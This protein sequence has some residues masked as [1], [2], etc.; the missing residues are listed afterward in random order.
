MSL[1]RII[2]YGSFDNIYLCGPESLI[3][4]ANK[5]L[6]SIGIDAKKIHFE[7]FTIPG[8]ATSVKSQ[9][10]SDSEI[11]ESPKS[12]I[13]IK[14]DGRS[15]GFELP[16]TGISI[17]DGALQQGADLPYACKGGVCATCRAKLVEGEVS[18]DVNY[19]LEPEEVEQGF[20]LTCQSHPKTAT[21]SV[22]FDIK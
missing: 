22:D 5:F 14:L 10:I 16:Y 7:L 9:I 3:S 2:S 19:A 13:T 1:Q 8:Q 15:F 11:S 20:I 18:M 17:L 4:T 6:A 12:N 21:V